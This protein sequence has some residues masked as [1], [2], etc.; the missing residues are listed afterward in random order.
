MST[1]S[2]LFICIFG[3][4]SVKEFF[5]LIKYYK[6]KK[7][8]KDPRLKYYTQEQINKMDGKLLEN[9]TNSTN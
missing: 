6:P 7:I 8:K 5:K 2:I 9:I 4:L 3:W 1:I